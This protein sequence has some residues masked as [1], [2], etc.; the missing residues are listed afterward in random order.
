MWKRTW[1]GRERGF[2][3]WARNEIEN[4]IHV[5]LFPALPRGEGRRK[6][7][8]SKLDLINSVSSAQIF[9]SF[10]LTLFLAVYV[11]R[12]ERSTYSVTNLSNRVTGCGQVF[13]SFAGEKRT[14]G[15][16][17]ARW[18]SDNW[19]FILPLPPF[20]TISSRLT[21]NFCSHKTPKPNDANISVF[22]SSS[23][24]SAP[25]RAGLPAYPNEWIERGKR[26]CFSSS[27][28]NHGHLGRT[29]PA[30]VIYIPSIYA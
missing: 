14:C 30:S 29:W 27:L 17:F 16:I 21:S 13:N 3:S 5:N 24:V 12:R 23:L 6:G 28:R 25:W 4:W 26:W 1:R 8:F 19:S 22:L 15:T 2:P 9:A 20:F 10:L 18:Q 7:E 11:F